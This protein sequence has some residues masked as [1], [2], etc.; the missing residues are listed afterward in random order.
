[1]HGIDVSTKKLELTWY[2]VKGFSYK[3]AETKISIKENLEL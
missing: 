3:E 1:M 2:L